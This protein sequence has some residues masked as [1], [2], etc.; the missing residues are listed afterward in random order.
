MKQRILV[1]LVL[2]LLAIAA[3]ARIG[4][5]DSYSSDSSSDSSS[6]SSDYSSSSDSSDYG[7]SSSSGG[8]GGGGGGAG[9]GL[10]T[11]LFI[12]FI[13]ISGA[14]QAAGR[15]SASNNTVITVAPT[16]AAPASMNRLREFDPNFSEIVFTDF[17]Y[18]L[19]ARLYEAQGRGQV[20]QLAPYVAAGIRDGLKKNA[21][22]LQSIDGLVIGSFT[23]T[24]F[25]G[26][27]TPNVEADVEF[28]TNYTE[29]AGGVSRRF[30]VNE[31]W[32]LTRARDLLSPAPQ[33]AKAE[34]CPK[35]G[36]AL[37][38]RTD[39]ACLHCGTIV[40]DGRFNWFVTA[41][42]VLK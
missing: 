42:R 41:I 4:G 8:G 6:S 26:I 10:I 14:F 32:T 33:N 15:A 29:V 23:V 18:S 37:Q 3:D 11:L 35:C 12:F 27:D 40:T 17:C 9:S 19:Y 21:P 1:V 38:T 39:G 13:F 16:R 5:G 36:A 34:H 24:G 22:G 28:E 30:Y 2:L 31:A 7:S 25:R 20:D